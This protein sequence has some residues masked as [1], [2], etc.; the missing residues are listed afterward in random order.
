MQAEFPNDGLFPKRGRALNYTVNGKTRM[1]R[2]ALGEAAVIM[3]N[4]NEADIY[5]PI[6]ANDRIEV[7]ESTAGEQAALDINQLPEYGAVMAVEVNEKRVELP[8]FAM[9]NGQ[10]Q[11]GYY[12]IHE[13]DV[14]EFQGYYTVRQ[15]ASTTA[16]LLLSYSFTL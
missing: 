16:S 1:A 6:H 12:G 2:G 7:T 4:G 10:L 9:V 3:V 8:K 13:N 11:S 14:I 5:T 15:A